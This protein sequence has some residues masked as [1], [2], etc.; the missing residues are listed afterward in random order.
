MNN[1]NLKEY[2]EQELIKNND[3]RN[4]HNHLKKL[5]VPELQE[6]SSQ[7]RL[8]W[9]VCLLNVTGDL[10]IGTMIRTA[11]CLG[12]ASV[13]IFGRRKYDKR[14]LVGSSNYI[15][16]DL[17]DGM[18]N[19]IELDYDKFHNM[20]YTKKFSPIFVEQ[21]GIPLPE[22]DWKQSHNTDYETCIVMGNETNGIPNNILDG[23]FGKTVSIPQKGV[24]RSMNVSSAMAI[25]ASHMCINLGWM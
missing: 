9:H 16:M 2:R 10:N 23:G 19:D 21:G 3:E 22:F 20:M 18:K 15:D 1:F 8:P 24:I 7:D 17:I 12:A 6:V 14:G 4:V 25:V 11:H 5:T 13:T